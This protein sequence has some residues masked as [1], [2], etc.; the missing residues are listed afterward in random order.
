MDWL[1]VGGGYRCESQ[2]SGTQLSAHLTRCC[3]GGW[4]EVRVA[5]LCVAAPV[6]SAAAHPSL[7]MGNSDTAAP[8]SKKQLPDPGRAGRSEAGPGGAGRGEVR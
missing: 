7:E 8:S 1:R 4:R 3:V 6:H 5:M 2:A